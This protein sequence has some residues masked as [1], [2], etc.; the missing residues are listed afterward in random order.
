M[1]SITVL[2]DRLTPTR[3]PVA[4]ECALTQCAK[5]RSVHP[6]DIPPACCGRA[7]PLPASERRAAIVDAVI[8]LVLTHGEMPTSRQIAAAAGVSEG[9]IFNVFADKSDLLEAVVSAVIDPTK[10]EEQIEGIE[11]DQPFAD[12]LEAAITEMQRRVVDVWRVLSIVPHAPLEPKRWEPSPAITALLADS[13][14]ALRFPAEQAS[15]MLRSITLALT[16]PLMSH[17]P[18]APSVIADMFLNGVTR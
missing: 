17:G 10:F 6:P 5:V 3:N 16:H 13:H 15:E 18:L 11:R 7:A 12:R 9:T 8:P 14:I 1:S 2:S 4:T